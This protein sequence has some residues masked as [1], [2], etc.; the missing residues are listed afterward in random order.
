M[1]LATQDSTYSILVSHSQIT[2]CLHL[3]NSCTPP[4]PLHTQLGTVHKDLLSGKTHE[5]GT[6]SYCRL[7]RV[8]LHVVK[9]TSPVDLHVHL[10]ALL[11]RLTRV[12]HCLWAFAQHTKDSTASYGAPVVWLWG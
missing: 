5:G 11:Q 7:T 12:M 6:W 8:L 9:P 3:C 10:T 4:P 2:F 1:H